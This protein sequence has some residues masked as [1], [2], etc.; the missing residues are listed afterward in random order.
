M[1]P[2]LLDPNRFGAPDPRPTKESDRFA[3]G[4][5]I[6]EVRALTSFFSPLRFSYGL[7]GAVRTRPIR[8]LGPREDQRCDIGRDSTL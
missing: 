8:R 2:E 3:L 5:V 1:S 6:Y 7:I 4:M